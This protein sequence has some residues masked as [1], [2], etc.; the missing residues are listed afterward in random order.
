MRLTKNK[1][2]IIFAIFSAISTLLMLINSYFYSKKESGYLEE[3]FEFIDYQG[4][5]P[6]SI[7]GEDFQGPTGSHP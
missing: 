1:I 6:G 3:Q 2:F 5:P 4:P 7:P